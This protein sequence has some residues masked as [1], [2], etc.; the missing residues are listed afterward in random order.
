MDVCFKAGE[1]KYFLKKD[2]VTGQ[3]YVSLIYLDLIK[4]ES[5]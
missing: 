5:Y 2:M 1:V 3:S 4:D